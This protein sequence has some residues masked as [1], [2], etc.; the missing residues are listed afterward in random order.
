[1]P[2][3]MNALLNPQ[4]AILKAWK[5]SGT[6][7]LSSKLDYDLFDRP[8][9][10][11]CLANAAR[12]ARALEIPKISALE[13][14][15]AGGRGLLAL[16]AL[17]PEIEQAYGV[18]IEVWGFDTGE[19]LPD[20][21]DYRDLPYI[22]KAGF[23]RMDQAALKA[24][25]KRSQLVLGD[26]KDTV[27]TFFETY[28]PAPLGAAFFDLDFWSSTL[29]SF[30]IFSGASSTMLPRVFCYCDDVISNEGGGVLSEDVGQLRAIGDYNAA[31]SDRKLRP[32]AGFPEK[33]RVRA[34][35][36]HQ[37]YVHHSFDHPNYTKYVHDDA[38]RQLAI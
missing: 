25:L 22:W 6:A 14:G 26:V 7:S 1:M 9:Y 27:P 15:V 20:P 36:P 2:K 28:K 12:L 13:F 24:K 29:D 38:D 17:C 5:V 35:W 21:V 32:I 23:Y 30:D 11:Y 10:A 37:I 4:R 8:H 31:S 34:V 18:E 19:G 33:R 16:E 3:L